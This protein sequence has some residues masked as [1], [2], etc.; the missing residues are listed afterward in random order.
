M[1]FIKAVFI[2]IIFFILGILG[3]VSTLT[4]FFWERTRFDHFLLYA[5]NIQGTGTF[6]QNTFFIC[7]IVVSMFL[8]L[9]ALYMTTKTRIWTAIGILGL[10]IYTFRVDGYITGIVETTEIYE[11]EYA[12]ATVSPQSAKRNLIVL[13]LE[14]LED[15]YRNVN[16]INLLPRLSSL[17][18]EH[19]SFPGFRQ[20]I[21]T[22]ATISAQ[23]G[24]ICALPYKTEINQINLFSILN[25]TL[26]NARCFPD[27]LK[28]NGYNTYF[29]KS[30]SIEFANTKRFVLQHGFD[31][32]EGINEILIKYPDIAKKATGNDWG[33][34]DSIM[35]ELTKEKL[36]E[37]AAQKQPFLVM[38]TTVDTHEPTPFLDPSCPKNYGDKRDIIFCADKMAADFIEWIQ[39]QD[40][41]PETTIVVMGDHISIGKNDILPQDQKRRIFNMIINPQPGLTAQ[42]HRWTTLD[43]APTILEAAGFD[44]GKLAL[45][46]SLWQKEPTLEEK[47]GLSLDLEFNKSSAFYR[48]L[49]AAKAQ[50]QPKFPLYTLN[51]EMKRT[52]DI[53][54]YTFLAHEEMGKVW[55]DHLN[56]Q[57]KAEDLNEKNI[58]LNIKFITLFDKPQ[59]QNLIDIK[60]NTKKIGQWKIAQNEKAPFEKEICFSSQDLP[61]DG[62]L[63]FEFRTDSKIN[64]IF[65]Q[66]IGIIDFKLSANNRSAAF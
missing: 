37:L 59:Q 19:Y 64:K 16:G 22:G 62:K 36:T 63:M 15:G 25:A 57:I 34:K 54:K 65:Y 41:Y 9:A 10:F 3:T 49:Q 18:D 66:A 47:Y 46:R 11:K 32:A 20:L 4:L 31:L 38:M 17:A 51:K 8:A 21:Y 45:G 33:I 5:V 60:L 24:G 53:R 43:L 61:E 6:I 30:G 2:A 7:G 39:K 26:P 48:Q 28:Q 52:D 14:S 42:K 27:I 40:F 13:Y 58:C 50:P 44:C 55:T 12:E 1:K 29:I 56:L 23:V 35:Y